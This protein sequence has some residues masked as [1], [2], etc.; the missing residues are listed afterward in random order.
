MNHTERQL[1]YRLPWSL[2][3]N[4]I[5]W[6][7]VT[8]VCNLSC[9][10]CYRATVTGHKTLAQVREEVDLM[11]AWRNPDN[12]S[13]SGG[14]PL[15][16]PDLLEIVAYI[17][18]CGLK[19][20]LLTNGVLLDSSRIRALKQAGL[21]GFTLH[22]DSTQARPG[23]A[24]CDELA[25]NA[26]RLE[27]ARMIAAVP[28]LVTVFNAT[29]TAATLAS[30]PALMRWACDHAQ[31][32]HGVVFITHRHTSLCNHSACDAHGAPVDPRALGYVQH[33]PA[34]P[35]VTAAE[36]NTA[37]TT[38]IPEYQPAGFLGGTASHTSAKWLAGIVLV[39]GRHVLGPVG[40]R[41]LEL[42]QVMYHVR[43]GR[44]LAYSTRTR[45]SLLALLLAVID[46]VLRRT[47]CAWLRGLL[48][49]PWRFFS[50]V[51]VLTIGVIQA[52]DILADGRV[53]M[54]DGCPDITWYAGQMVNSCRLDECRLFGAF[55]T[56]AQRKPHT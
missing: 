33:A 53:D 7:E 13:I 1:L 43:R 5:A 30:V 41:T 12:V 17:H 34:A 54:C 32:V 55:L 39:T 36:I 49:R 8:D 3:D 25:L 44:Y 21:A 18:A 16:H 38:V 51:H 42:A 22:V 20:V 47:A 37:I 10:G 56:P 24:A 9:A 40:R 52:P 23:W 45:V 4:P 14:E 28:G 26:L 2:H 35:H 11:R 31:I 46:P 48:R 15:L 19:P 50:R 29:V 6:I 27:L